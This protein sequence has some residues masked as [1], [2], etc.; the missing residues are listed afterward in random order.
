MDLH[1]LE[2]FC[3]VVEFRSFTL[4]A[5]A[6]RLSQPTVSEHIRS[7]E[8]MVGDKLVDRLGREVRLTPA[9][10]ILWR[11]AQKLLHLRDEAYQALA[12]HRGELLGR[13]DI[14]ASTIPGSYLLPRLLGLFKKRYP[15]IHITL[16]IC[17]TAA[18]AEMVLKGE[19]G[20]GLAGSQVPDK[21]L[22]FEEVY[23]DELNL[24]VLPQ[25]PWAEREEV[26][27]TELYGQPY[28][29]RERGSG[30]QMAVKKILEAHGLEFHKL[31]V[32]A[33][34]PNTEAVRQSILAGLGL[35]ILSR[36][37]VASDLAHGDL[38]AVKIKGVV[39]QR[40][41]YLVS[42]QGREIPPLYATFGAVLREG[43]AQIMH[44]GAAK[45]QA[46]ASIP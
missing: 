36:L 7:L 43:V 12:N 46:V 22:L 19:I 15:A 38:V 10:Q 6:L 32:A 14:G 17:N 39:L 5:E 9:G 18:V 34:M 28:I 2:I 23:L 11:Y 29:V 31:T 33:E 26:A 1:R 30:T 4:A 3:K 27:L 41:L 13:L 20:L 24:V 37:A 8:E 16:K 35:S 25:H 42:R 45:A 21:R 44:P 40:P